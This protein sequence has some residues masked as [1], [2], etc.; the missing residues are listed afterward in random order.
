MGIYQYFQTA[1]K[2][3]LSSIFTL[4]YI[5]SNLYETNFIQNFLIF[6]FDNTK[7]Y[8]IP[9]MVIELSIEII[10]KHHRHTLFDLSQKCITLYMYYKWVKTCN[11]LLCNTKLLQQKFLVVWGLNNLIMDFRFGYRWNLM[12]HAHYA[13]LKFRR[14]WTFIALHSDSE[15]HEMNQ[16]PSRFP[17]LF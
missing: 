12:V 9:S 13:E 8:E 6:S 2:F 5:W 3:F 17:L 1:V 7:W 16:I 15:I 10:I 14:K 11:S 4:W